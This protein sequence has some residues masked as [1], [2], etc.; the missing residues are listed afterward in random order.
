MADE[1]TQNNPNPAELELKADGTPK[2]LKS[3]DVVAPQPNP[4]GRPTTYTPELAAEILA[5][6]TIGESLRTA[7]KPDHLPAIST[8]YLWMRDQSELSEQYARAKAEAADAMSEDILDI[9]DD[10]TNDWMADNYDEGKTPGYSFMGEHV[11]RSKL[12]IETRRWLMSKLKARKYGDKLDLTTGGDK[13][14]TPIY[15]GTAV[16]IDPTK[17]TKKPG[18]D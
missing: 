10:A 4:V 3:E 16:S 13:L 1:Q 17:S 5:S 15:G 7:C 2:V 8:W 6:L 11:Q 12:R 14:P 18:E 9:A